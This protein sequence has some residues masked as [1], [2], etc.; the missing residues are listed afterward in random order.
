MADHT[1]RTQTPGQHQRTMPADHSAPTTKG[2]QQGKPPGA[3]RTRWDGAWAESGFLHDRWEDLL[4]A[5]ELG[6]RHMA[7]WIKAVLAVAGLSLVV[8]LL[9]GAAG[10]LADAVHQLLTAAPHVQVATNTS[11]GVFAVIDQPI[12]TYIATHT[13]SLQISGSTVYTVWQLV[14]LFGLV[15]GFF[16]GTGARLTWTAWGAASIAMVYSSTPAAGRP[17]ATGLAVLAWTAASALALR[18]LSLRPSL[19]I[20]NAAP[21]VRPEIRPEIH[22]PAPAGPPDGDAPNNVL[23]LQKR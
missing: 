6:W 12:R 9:D 1:D 16:R 15:G 22:V 13:A 7:N 2:P 10:V 3:L 23:P 5:R 17:I 18:G 4:Q 11:S 14:G 21:Q 8:L 19:F 20:H